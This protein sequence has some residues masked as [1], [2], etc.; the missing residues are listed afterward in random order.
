M[1]RKLF[2]W[3]LASSAIAAALIL[4]SEDASASGRIVEIEQFG[5]HE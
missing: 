4:G 1:K 2:R 5:T 3:W